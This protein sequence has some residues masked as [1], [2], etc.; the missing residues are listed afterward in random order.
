MTSMVKLRKSCRWVLIQLSENSLLRSTRRLLF[1]QLAERSPDLSNSQRLLSLIQPSI[2]IES[3]NKN[4]AHSKSKRYYSCRCAGMPFSSLLVIFLFPSQPF[5][6][7]GFEVESSKPSTPNSERQSSTSM[8]TSH[9]RGT[10][11][12]LTEI[13]GR[14]LLSY[15][16]TVSRVWKKSNNCSAMIDHVAWEHYLHHH[17]VHWIHPFPRISRSEAGKW[18]TIPH[19]SSAYH[20][21]TPEE[22]PS[23]CDLCMS[24]LGSGHYFPGTELMIRSC[25]RR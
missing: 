23:I 2:V 3:L 11:D 9:T 18:T 4:I 21:G 12:S 17:E 24:P 7:I 19:V 13:R 15:C 6:D 1:V 25:H 5:A 14:D 22:I 20:S 10:S 8:K 16:D